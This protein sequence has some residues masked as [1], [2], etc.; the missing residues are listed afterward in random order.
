M[1]RKVAKIVQPRKFDFFEEDIPKLQDDQLLLKIQSCGICHSE[2]S[3]YLG[4]RQLGAEDLGGG[5]SKYTVSDQAIYP[6]IIGHEPVA[7]VTDKGKNVKE[8]D[9]GDWVS[10]F[11]RQS[12]CD[13]KITD[14]AKLIKLGPEIFDKRKLLIEPPACAVN[15]IRAAMVEPGHHVVVIGCGV[16]GLL[17]ISGLK[18]SG[19]FK[20]IAIDFIDERLK[21][22][23][24]LGATHIINAKKEDSIK[25]VNEL[26]EGE[27]ADIVIEITG[28]LAGFDAACQ[29]IKTK[30]KILIASQYSDVEPMRSGFYLAIKSPIMI[31]PH[32]NYSNDFTRD[33]Q[34]AYEAYIKKGIFPI[35][36]L[37][38]HTFNF[39][40]INEAFEKSISNDPKYIHGIVIM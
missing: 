40:D 26:T 4:E 10:G 19:A 6:A 9:E 27:N 22:A 23:L 25:S 18:N 15:I 12:F 21:K 36:N 34:I 28:K 35:D 38:T 29:M 3:V 20:I 5:K 33:M 13:Y 2:T 8:F 17:C 14:T 32:P 37:I 30:G 1:K 39:E 11:K 24:E 16:M 7:I 31:A